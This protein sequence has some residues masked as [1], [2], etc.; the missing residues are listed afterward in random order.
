MHVKHQGNVGYVTRSFSKTITY[1]GRQWQGLNLG[2]RSVQKKKSWNN[3]KD[4]IHSIEKG[5]SVIENIPAFTADLE[6]LK[7]REFENQLLFY[8]NRGIIRKFLMQL[9]LAPS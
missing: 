9:H 4:L 8:E 3:P 7:I 1:R 2:I 6:N 5:K